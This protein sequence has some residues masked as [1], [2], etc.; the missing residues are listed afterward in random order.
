ME[1]RDIVKKVCNLY[2]T[3]GIKSIT[4]DDVAHELG[5]SKKTLYQYFSD[6]SELVS[7]AVTYEFQ[8]K[9]EMFALRDCDKMNAMEEL[10]HYYMI[11]VKMI[12]EY[13]PG[14]VYDLRKY[15]PTIY[16]N[17]IRIKREKILDSVVRNLKKG[18]EE[19]FFRNELN[20]DIISRLTLMRIEGMLH[21]GLFTNEEMMS[22][23][24]FTE[25]FN[26]HV[27]GIVTEKGRRYFE[28]NKEQLTYK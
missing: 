27:Y 28:E 11:Q 15:Y 6:K 7:E 8:I 24:V 17:Y 18:K 16:E 21:S 20:E 9:Q 10:L 2:K 25:I 22:P 12:L 1:K 19:G 4:M 23:K 14:F 13:N 3:Y 26:Y 5:I